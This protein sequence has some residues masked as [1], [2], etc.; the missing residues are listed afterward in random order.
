MTSADDN[1]LFQRVVPE[2]GGL[3][4]KAKVTTSRFPQIKSM[5][6]EATL[7]IDNLVQSRLKLRFMEDDDVE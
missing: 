7:E 1:I 6:R 5:V 2:H 4:I 3:R